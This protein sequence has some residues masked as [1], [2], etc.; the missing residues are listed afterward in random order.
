MLK[1]GLTGGIGTGKSLVSAIMGDCGAH[2]IDADLLGHES[3]NIGTSGLHQVVKVFGDHILGADGSIDRDVLG[4]IVFNDRSQMQNLNNIL[5]PIIYET[6]KDRIGQVEEDGNTMVVVEAAV[7][8]EAQW[9]SLFDQ[10]WVVKS[11]EETVIRRL[12]RRNG[13]DRNEACKRIESQISESDRLS[14]ADVII[15]NNGTR[16]ELEVKV[17]DLWEKQTNGIIR[18]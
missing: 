6:V 14:H 1:V 16:E 15:D 3:Y 7:L 5:H 9:Q 4:R 13:F 17:K 8:I 11:D 12:L 2:L 10:V 18:S